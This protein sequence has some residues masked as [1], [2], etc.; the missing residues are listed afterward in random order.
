[1][2]AQAPTFV[3]QEYAGRFLRMEPA[4]FTLRIALM[5]CY[6]MSS[7]KVALYYL[8]LLVMPSVARLAS[9]R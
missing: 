5:R 7:T 1:M 2:Q 6:G 4:L 8:L 9:L 3:G